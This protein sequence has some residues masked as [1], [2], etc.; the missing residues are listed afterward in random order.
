[1]THQLNIF[2]LLF[3]ALQGWLLSLWFLKRQEKKLSNLY[4]ALFL[5]VV[6]LQLTFK[7]ISKGWLME[8]VHLAYLLSYDLPYLAGPFVFLYIRARKDNSFTKNDL[9]HF[10][11]F[12][13]SVSIT[14]AAVSINSFPIRLHPYTDMVLQLTSISTYCV[15]ALRAGNPMLRRFI[16]AVWLAESV[17]IVTLA[18]MVLYYPVFPDVRLLFLSLTILIYWISYQAISKPDLFIEAPAIPVL[19]IFIKKGKKY[20]HSSLKSEEANRIE[21][22][23]R[24]V[25]GKDKLYLDPDLTIESLAARIK[26]S[27]HHISQVI[28]ERLNKTYADYVADL[29]L[30][31][32]RSRLSNP[33]NNR[34]TIAAIALDSGFNS[35]SSFNEIFKKRYGITPS[36]FRDQQLNK[37]TA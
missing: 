14:V 28:N 31:E 3:G 10:L 6:G 37:M 20:A 5:I 9:V 33:A 11:P 25:M 36:K 17:I 26:T 8:N 24:Q 15:L 2:L 22:A 23:L 12:L 19:E 18:V 16:S 35:V 29:R 34:F 32:A 1:M 4:F 30:E 21:E 7:V 13:V 27:R